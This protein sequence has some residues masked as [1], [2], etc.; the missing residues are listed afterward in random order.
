MP[1]VTDFYGSLVTDKPIPDHIQ[2]YIEFLTEIDT[3]ALSN[4]STVFP[5]AGFPVEQVGALADKGMYCCGL[6][7]S[8]E[9]EI[10]PLDVESPACGADW[11]QALL[12]IFL[13]PNGINAM[14]RIHAAGEAGTSDLWCVVVGDDQV[15]HTYEGAVIYE[16]QPG[17]PTAATT[18]PTDPGPG[19]G[20]A[21]PRLGIN[22]RHRH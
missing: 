22:R 13:H 12:D 5:P 17:F 4:T 19:P 7:C 14:G 1:Y 15:V 2:A 18:S 9:T 20:L 16:D 10:E 21:P 3:R 8:S 6:Y 11:V